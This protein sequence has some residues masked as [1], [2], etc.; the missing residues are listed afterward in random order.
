MSARLPAISR[1]W[2]AAA[3]SFA[4]P[5]QSL[6]GTAQQYRRLARRMHRGG[7]CATA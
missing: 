4:A 5:S 7:A 6:L 2:P 3:Q 1:L